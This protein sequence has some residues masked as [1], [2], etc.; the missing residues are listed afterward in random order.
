MIGQQ[1]CTRLAGLVLIVSASCASVEGRSLRAGA[2]AIDVSP[3]KF[4]VVV[5]G[6]FL[7]SSANKVH[8][9]L[10]ARALVLDDGTTRMAIVV[11]DSCMLPR[12]LI[13]RAKKIAHE[14][15]SIPVER[16]LV[17]STHTHSAPSAMGALG[18]RADADYVGFLPERIAAAIER[19][20]KN[21]EPAEA[22]WGS[23]DDLE[24]THCRRWIRRS[25]RPLRDPFGVE[26]VR[27]NMHPGHE[28]PDVIG[29]SGPVDPGLSVLAVRATNGRPIALLANYSMHYFGADPV[30]S[31][32]FGR[33]SEAIAR[34][35]GGDVDRD[36]PFVAMM[37][38]GTS[39]DQQ[40]MDYAKPR[41]SITLDQY[42]D[43]LAARA[44]Q[45][46]RTL[47]FRDLVPLAMA[48]TRVTLRR[49]VP[50]EKRLAWARTVLGAIGERVPKSLEEV[51]A[52]EA[53]FLKEEP[54]RE[55]KLQA[56]R[57]GELGI[58]A[59]PD[60]V[61]A[62]TGLKIKARS[63]LSRTF[64][65]ELA[66]GSEGY[67]PPP[68]QHALGGYTTW[69]ARTAGLE[70][71]AEPKIVEEILGLLERVSGRTRRKD[72]EPNGPYAE[73]VLAS[74][75]LA[76][77]RLAEMDGKEAVDT[78]GRGNSALYTK[79]VAFF[80]EGPASSA[81]SGEGFNNHAAHFAGG[82][83]AAD[84][85]GL[86]STWSVELWFWNGLTDQAPERYEVLFSV[87][88]QGDSIGVGG[89]GF[90]VS[91][92]GI[93]SVGKHM[94]KT[95]VAPRTWHHVVLVREGEGVSV[96]LDGR[97][98]MMWEGPV[99]TFQ[100]R[101]HLRFGGRADHDADFE[102]KLDEVAVYDRGL[103]ASE[104]AD[105]FKVS[106]MSGAQGKETQGGRPEG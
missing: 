81:F 73:A 41:S 95:R 88:I 101:V 8:D 97:A 40:W 24:Q 31:D 86:K 91:G 25:D 64:T 62:L 68:E 90:L 99:E 84:L 50:D 29:P 7:E 85:A 78:T 67:I 30:S 1:S 45:V 87:G 2:A 104:V 54:V 82:R 44:L 61:Y 102:G 60:E 93:A 74:R 100:D 51:Y 5:N 48:E 56:I 55:L 63:P 14:R 22:G 3:A 12:E 6:G 35:V 71:E 17:S 38:Q 27:A 98:E 16:V 53:L 26:S 20:V 58:A 28:S 43:T 42:A 9:R 76:Y 69:P 57:V 89:R 77:W 10:H 66:N 18:S 37:S 105:H 75:P 46:Y 59:I 80:L 49:R 19:A 83:L 103:R 94:G 15:T 79:G 39:G 21:L 47:D 13:D 52:R 11:V 65:I 92:K 96:Y 36:R 106:G 23:V 33:F 34:G 4:P 72:Q 32:Y 70:V